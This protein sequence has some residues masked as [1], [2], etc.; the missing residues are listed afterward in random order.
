[1]GRRSDGGI[2]LR[3]IGPNLFCQNGQLAHMGLDDTNL[4]TRMYEVS[5]TYILLNTTA[6]LDAAKAYRT[7]GI[8]VPLD[9]SFR[10]RH[11]YPQKLWDETDRVFLRPKRYIW[12]DFPMVLV[13]IFDVTLDQGIV[14]LAVLCHHLNYGPIRKIFSQDQYPQEFE[15]ISQ[16]R[17]RQDG[18]YV[19]EL[20]LQ[21]RS[22]RAMTNSTRAKAGNLYHNISGSLYPQSIPTFVGSVQVSTLCFNVEGRIT[23]RVPSVCDQ[24]AGKVLWMLGALISQKTGQTTSLLPTVWTRLK[25]VTQ[26]KTARG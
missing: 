11:T 13:M 1:M 4:Q 19:Q 9:T 5:E 25:S 24:K 18:I 8:H 12:A 15:V 2:C 7:Q 3:K 20:D 23:K 16:A 22:T 17:Y 21:A 10:S 26:R 6:A 14:S